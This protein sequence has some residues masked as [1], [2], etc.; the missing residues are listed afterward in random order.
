[1]SNDLFPSAQSPVTEAGGIATRSWRD[2]FASLNAIDTTS[3][4]AEITALQK[5]VNAIPGG[6]N[7]KAQDSIG[8]TGN[9]M[10][11]G[12]VQISLIGDTSSPPA[13][14]FY[15]CLT[16]GNR[17]WQVFSAAFV[18]DMA[19]LDLSDTGVTA[20]TYGDASHY[21]VVT[22]DAKGRVDDI[23]LFPVSGGGG[24][25]Y[26]INGWLQN[27]Q[28]A[29]TLTGTGYTAD[30]WLTFQQG[31]TAVTSRVNAA[32]GLFQGD[33]QY[34][35]QIVVGAGS[36]DTDFC[37]YLQ[38]IESVRTLAGQSAFV[39]FQVYVASALTIAVD[40][41]Q[42][43][44]TGGGSVDGI[45]T[46]KI[47]LA[48]GVN[49]VSIPV[50]IPE[51]TVPLGTPDT[52]WLAVVIW[53][54]AGAYY[55]SRTDSLGHQSGT[56]VLGTLSL[57]T[58]PASFTR[59]DNANEL[60]KCQRFLEKS[61]PQATIPAQ[62]AGTAGCVYVPQVVGASAFQAVASVSFK[63]T[64]RVAPAVT[65]YNP[66]A[67]NAMVRN[68]S[69]ATDWTLSSI[70]YTGDGAFGVAGT[71]PASSAAGQPAIFHWLADARY[72][73]AGAATVAYVLSPDGVEGFVTDTGAIM[74]P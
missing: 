1:M 32:L 40:L 30:G 3:I 48:A 9:S 33:P 41:V 36:A 42:Y 45:G 17:G 68:A 63:T 69:T 22:V 46:T 19:Q 15:G 67:T 52:D 5:Q 74:I 39:Q 50:A 38:L 10:V 20:G 35:T 7:L 58:I 51:I 73:N 61:F 64:K 11:G 34:L 23:T 49:L 8:M 43:M 6:F 13:L 56:F 29:T 71:S 44:G 25:N 14:S 12:L 59:P 24:Q 18:D 47:T 62:N 66:S 72:T 57:T 65:L 2:W 54:D 26:L 53:F 4:Q 55:D 21:P 31:A 28:V 16:A 70:T 60:E 37:Q 27:W